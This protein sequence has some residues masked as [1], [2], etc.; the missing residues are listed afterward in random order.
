MAIRRRGKTNFFLL[1]DSVRYVPP[2][3]DEPFKMVHIVTRL[4]RNNC[5]AVDKDGV[6]HSFPKKHLFLCTP[7][8]H[9]LD[10]E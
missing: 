10:E 9:L 1:G 7:D 3:F 8:G 4:S 6:V 5:S 2:S